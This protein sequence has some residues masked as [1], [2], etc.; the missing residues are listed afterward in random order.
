MPIKKIA[1]IAIIAAAIAAW[2]HFG[3]GSYLQ[4]DTLQQRGRT[5]PGT[6]TTPR[7]PACSTSH[8]MS[9]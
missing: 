7:W 8:C 2:F 6:P 4:F 9:P 5:A 1:V 3:L